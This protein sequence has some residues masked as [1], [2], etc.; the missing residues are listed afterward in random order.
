MNERIPGEKIEEVRVTEKL[1]EIVFKEKNGMQEGFIIYNETPEN[2]K[3]LVPTTLFM[4]G[5]KQMMI[6]GG[7]GKLIRCNKPIIGSLHLCI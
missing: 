2:H 3:A 6:C 4:I 5:T 1:T 7:C